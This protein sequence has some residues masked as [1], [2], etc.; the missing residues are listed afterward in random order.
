MSEG[1]CSFEILLTI[2]DTWD[3]TSLTKCN[4]TV[5]IFGPLMVLQDNKPNKIFLC[6]QYSFIKLRIQE[7]CFNIHVFQFEIIFATI[8]MEIKMDL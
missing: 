3:M 1:L 6:H 5:Y 2:T 8:A 7:C 4:L